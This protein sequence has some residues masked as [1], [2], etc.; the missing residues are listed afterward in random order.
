[1]LI[2]AVHEVTLV[3]IFFLIKMYNHSV[4]QACPQKTHSLTSG[5]PSHFHDRPQA[6]I[7]LMVPQT[8]ARMIKN[9]VVYHLHSCASGKQMFLCDGCLVLP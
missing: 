5:Q 2:G 9:Y 6:G 7:K 8:A 4:I 3:L 1:M